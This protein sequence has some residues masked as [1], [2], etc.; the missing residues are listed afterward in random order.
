LARRSRRRLVITVVA[1]GLIGVASQIAT[2]YTTSLPTPVWLQDPWHLWSVLAGLV[3]AGAI[4]ALINEGL[5]RES[6]PLTENEHAVQII[7][8]ASQNKSV[9]QLTSN[10]AVAQNIDAIIPTEFRYPDQVRQFY[11]TFQSSTARVIDNPLRTNWIVQGPAG[12]GKSVLLHRIASTICHTNGNVVAIVVPLA[13]YDWTARNIIEWAANAI[14]E[15]TDVSADCV[16][17]L[18]ASNRLL[19]LLDGLDEVPDSRS[20]RDHILPEKELPLLDRLLMRRSAVL[21]PRRRLLNQIHN[22]PNFILTSRD[23]SSPPTGNNK[24]EAGLVIVK[25]IPPQST[26]DFLARLPSSWSI[27]NHIVNV[28]A[29][30]LYLQLVLIACDNVDRPP[31]E[32]NC[33][34]EGIKFHLWNIYLDRALPIEEGTL[35]GWDMRRLRRWFKSYSIAI[36]DR[37]INAISFQWWPL[38][39][40][41][42]VRVAMRFAKALLSVGIL[43]LWILPHLVVG[44]W[45]STAVAIILLAALYTIAGEGPAT[46][47][48]T[49]RGFSFP[50]FVVIAKRQWVYVVSFCAAGIFL[51][52][53]LSGNLP[54]P[55]IITTIV[56]SKAVEP[57]F[58]EMAT[59][60]GATGIAVGSIVPTLYEIFYVAN[61]HG[62]H[63]KNPIDLVRSTALAAATIGLWSSLAAVPALWILFGQTVALIAIPLFALLIV[64]DTLGSPWAAA[65]MWAL[66]RKGPLRVNRFLELARQRGLVR[67]VGP[68]YLL[69]HSELA[70][71]QGERSEISTT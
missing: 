33:D 69:E 13:T 60:G 63:L 32:A 34:E 25:D 5:P 48:M 68:Y 42:P 9:E 15:S 31:P 40:S 35:A 51:T 56:Y 28:V 37:K 70:R 66:K 14:S 71:I 1:T 67:M 49:L 53:L 43:C 45:S 47:P 65:L 55:F 2:K 3:F 29:S 4:L 10:Q 17:Q 12:S 6:E 52:L 39:F 30:P 21:D 27:N 46:R 57:D 18:L 36:K 61:S 8:Q 38:L 20:L 22:I 44:S 58:W 54:A 64:I 16:K 41:P 62:N 59:I 11:G 24:N 50:E 26:S 23:W 19:V 7:R